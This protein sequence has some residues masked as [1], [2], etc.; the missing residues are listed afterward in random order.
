MNRILPFI[1]VCF[2]YFLFA[3][4]TSKYLSSYFL[5][6]ISFIL[7]SYISAVNV[8]LEKFFS[9]MFKIPK[10]ITEHINI[11]LR[12]KRKICNIRQSSEL[13][14]RLPFKNFNEL[15]GERYGVERKWRKQGT[16]KT[17]YYTLYIHIDTSPHV[18]YLNILFWIQLVCVN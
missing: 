11:L 6:Y 8:F 18:Y 12:K 4:G 15:R 2:S 10:A 13:Q 17:E 3:E 1:E 9:R 5:F 16:V 7:Y 14:R